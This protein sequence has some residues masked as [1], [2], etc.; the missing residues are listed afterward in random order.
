MNYQE[1]SRHE[2]TVEALVLLFYVA[3]VAFMAIGFLVKR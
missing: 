3:I 2:R 1:D